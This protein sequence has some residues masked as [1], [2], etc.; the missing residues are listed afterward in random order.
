MNRRSDLARLQKLSQL[1]L[2]QRLAKLRETADLRDRTRMQIMSL[3]Q[4]AKTADL[5]TVTVN[6]V[7]L[8]YELW[9]DA[10]RT[11]LNAILARQTVDWL[12]AR[13]RALAAFGRL[14]ALRGLNRNAEGES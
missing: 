4:S 13:D 3:D 11:E 5:P 2:D 7:A 12:D 9:A 10:Q 6:Q 14:E 8:R 1:I